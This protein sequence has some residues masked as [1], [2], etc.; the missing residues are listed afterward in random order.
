MAYL[1]SVFYINLKHAQPK[2][3]TIKLNNKISVEFKEISRSA[4][5]KN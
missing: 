3:L 5:K 1:C 2:M 4:L